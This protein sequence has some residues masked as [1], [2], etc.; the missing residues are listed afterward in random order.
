MTAREMHTV[1]AG[2]STDHYSPIGIAER[3]ETTPKRVPSTCSIRAIQGKKLY[4]ETIK[5]ISQGIILFSV[6]L[7]VL[8]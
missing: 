7:Y 4:F 8:C 6:N 5:I 2:N 3:W 1:T